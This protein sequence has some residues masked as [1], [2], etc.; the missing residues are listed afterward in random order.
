MTLPKTYILSVFDHVI[1]KNA[2]VHAK[3]IMFGKQKDITRN[4]YECFIVWQ[5]P[6]GKKLK[7]SCK[8]KNFLTYQKAETHE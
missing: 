3:N 7:N 8:I 2:Q 5:E 6:E 1:Y 4:V